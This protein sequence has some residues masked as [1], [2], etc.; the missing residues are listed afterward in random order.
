M[1]FTLLS[2]I[3]VVLTVPV[4]VSACEGECIVSITKAFLGNYTTPVQNVLEE[5]A[6]R[7]T[8]ILPTNTA[9]NN[10]MHSLHYLNPIKE[11][12]TQ[13]AY[14]G[15]EN[16]IFPS[17]FHGKCLDENGNEPEGCPNPDCPIVCGT[18]GSLVHFYT[19]LRYIAFNQTRHLLKELATPGT[20]SYQEVE[21]NVLAAARA[22][23]DGENEKRKRS[24][25]RFWKRDVERRDVDEQDIKRK[26]KNVLSGSGGILEAVCGGSGSGE[27]NGLSKCSWEDAMKDYIL[28]F[29]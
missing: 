27:T 2:S 21:D 8:T 6:D 11:S 18:P 14:D 4:T 19:K 25:S 12:Y 28:T 24:G 15:M 7:I 1:R 23:D 3:L 17:Y 22:S 29:P 26:L 13:K 10:Q 9:H 16:A 20:E 5:L